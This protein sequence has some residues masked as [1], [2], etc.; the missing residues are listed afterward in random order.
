MIRNRIIPLCIVVAVMMALVSVSLAQE[1]E[2]ININKASAAELAQLKRIGP[3]LSERIVEYREKHG[4]FERPE[5]IMQV[6]GI[7]PKTFEL[8][9]DR[10]TTE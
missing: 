2:K 9:K 6:K 7:G 5:D 1:A 8:N 3:K 10:I 4:P